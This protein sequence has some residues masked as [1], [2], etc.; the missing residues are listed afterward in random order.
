VNRKI[1]TALL[2]LAAFGGCHASTAPEPDSAPSGE[3]EPLPAPRAGQ[4][5]LGR[6]L[7]LDELEGWD[8]APPPANAPVTLVRWW[9]D[10]CPWCEASLPAVETL[11]ARFSDR[12]LAVVGVYHPK[13]P[14]S[15]SSEQV[16]AW[17]LERGY[18]GTLA[19][20]PEWEVLRSFW[21]DAGSRRATSASFVLDAA[22]TIRFVH[23]GPVFFPSERADDARENADY[24]DL[25]LAIERLLV[26]AGR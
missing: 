25:A 24:E 10:T 8:P 26:E 21:L 1:A 18:S 11:R 19:H 20:D 17:A 6:P 14:R 15:V 3:L 4:E 9:T 7:P 22:G 13:P 16:R 2:A 12:G 23:P 5:L